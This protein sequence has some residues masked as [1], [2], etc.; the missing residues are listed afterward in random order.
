[1]DEQISWIRIPGYMRSVFGRN[2]RR[3]D[4]KT[5][6]TSTMHE[7]RIAIVLATTGGSPVHEMAL[8]W[9]VKNDVINRARLSRQELAFREPL[10]A[11]TVGEFYSIIAT[12][13]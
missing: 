10:R 4:V 3:I 5:Y 12:S 7:D 11:V 9:I 8:V 2:V 13:L 1:M 6:I